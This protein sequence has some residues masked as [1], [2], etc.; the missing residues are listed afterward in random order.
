M[1]RWKTYQMTMSHEKSQWRH[2][3]AIGNALLRELASQRNSVVAVFCRP[4]LKTEDDFISV[5]IS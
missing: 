1:L 3:K 4:G 2:P 5:N